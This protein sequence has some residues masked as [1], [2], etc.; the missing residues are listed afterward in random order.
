[1][2]PIADKDRLTRLFAA[3]VERLNSDPALAGR[4]AE[5]S[6]AL[7]FRLD[8]LDSTLVLD[9]RTVPLRV[10]SGRTRLTPDTTIVTTS[11]QFHDFWSG[12]SRRV[13]YP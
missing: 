13:R 9:A 12:A 8:D 1:M 11:P 4:L 10:P 7:G 2:P 3:F 5:L 6:Q